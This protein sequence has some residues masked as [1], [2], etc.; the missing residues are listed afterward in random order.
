MKPSPHKVEMTMMTLSSKQGEVVPVLV[1]VVDQVPEE[2]TRKNRPKEPLIRA[3][4][5]FYIS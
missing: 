1:L 5:S 4:L 2:E 3:A